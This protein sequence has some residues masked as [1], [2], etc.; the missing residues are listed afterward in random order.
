MTVRIRLHDDFSQPEWQMWMENLPRLARTLPD[1][2]LLRLGRNRVYWVEHQGERFV[3]KHFINKGPW[4]KIAYRISSGKARRSYEHS[5][6]L[7]RAGLHSPRPVGWRE[8]WSGGFLKESYYISRQVPIAHTMRAIRSVS[9]IDWL[10]HVERVGQAIARMHEAGL[11]HCDMA[12]GN[13]LFVENGER[14][15]PI[16]FID[17][18]RMRFGKIG[19]RQGIRALLQPKVRGAL[20]GPFVAAYASVR[21]FDPIT[22]LDLY[23]SLLPG[24]NRKWRIKNLTR[25]WRRK[26]GL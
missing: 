23:N 4:K 14:D 1:S 21:G 22:C 12:G 8:D 26:V 19:V 6:A 10:P 16:Y 20:A 11:F 24:Y 25:P 15:W 5:E 18:N 9:E 7:L 3:L 17:T 2:Q 13:I